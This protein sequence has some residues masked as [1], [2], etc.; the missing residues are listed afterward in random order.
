MNIF[1]ILVI[2]VLIYVVYRIA[3]MFG[4]AKIKGVKEYR[5][6]DVLSKGEDLMQDPFCKTYVP[7]SQAYIREIDG[8]RQYFCS[9]ECCEKYLSGK[10]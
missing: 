10:K 6:D 9:K 7:M 2:F 3:R 4:S 5:T 8:A 1:R